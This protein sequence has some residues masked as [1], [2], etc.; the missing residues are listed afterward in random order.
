[1]SSIQK[2]KDKLEALKVELQEDIREGN[3][4]DQEFEQ[5]TKRSKE[6]EAKVWNCRY[7]IRLDGDEIVKTQCIYRF[8]QREGGKI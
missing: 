8:L 1:M 4:I 3:E 7:K 6:L 2:A 5:S